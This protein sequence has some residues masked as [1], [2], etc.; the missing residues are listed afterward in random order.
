MATIGSPSSSSAGP[1][2]SRTGTGEEP[3]A[4]GWQSHWN[5]FDLESSSC[6]SEWRSSGSCSRSEAC[7][8]RLRRDEQARCRAI[9]PVQQKPRKP[10]PH[11]RGAAGADRRKR[12]RSIS[13]LRRGD[14]DGIFAP[15]VLSLNI[16]GFILATSVK[17][18]FPTMFQAAFFAERG[19]LASYGAADGDWAARRRGSSTGSSRA[20][21]RPICR[22]N[23]RRNSS[24]SSI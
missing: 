15:R 11:A 20:P 8:P 24:S 18:T 23:S 3:G 13:G 14:V 22:S 7:S 5:R 6:R 1:I 9:G 12:A 19:G 21:G 16:P 17:G 2:P 10:R 4:P